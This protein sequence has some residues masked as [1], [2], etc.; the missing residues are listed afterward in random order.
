MNEGLYALAAPEF[1]KILPGIGDPAYGTYTLLDNYRGLFLRTNENNAESIFEVQFD[2]LT[3][4]AG[5]GGNDVNWIFQNFTLNRTSWG[6]IWFNF[7]VPGFKLNEFERWPENI[8]AD[9]DSTV[10]DYRAY[11][12]L[13]G[14]PGGANFTA[15]GT[16]KNWY[17]QGWHNESVIGVAGAYGIRKYALDNTAD[18]PTG[19]D[20]LWSDNNVRI[21]RLGDIYLRYA[22]CMAQ[23]NP[24]NV[25]P[26]DVNS[27]VYWVDKIRERANR[28]MID[29]AQLLSARAGVFG[30]LPT[31]TALMAAKGWTLMQLIEHE[32]FV[33]GFGEGWRK[34][35]LKR[36]KKGATYVTGKSGWTGWESLILPLPQSELDRNP[37]YQ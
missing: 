15:A 32:R 6:T 5:F 31:A 24:G 13:W 37:N 35:D 4:G 3:G 22:E 10:Y 26:T 36:W 2:N 14:V 29:Q 20:P 18:A 7:A 16:V 33:E 21:I 34:E 25:T 8:G 9:P 12:T 1:A 28:P 23:L 30:Q 19:L 27:A 17:A 11:A